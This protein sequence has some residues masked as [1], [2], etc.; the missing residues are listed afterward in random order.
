MEVPLKIKYREVTRLPEAHVAGA[1]SARAVTNHGECGPLCPAHLRP[2]R[3]FVVFLLLEQ[4][5]GESCVR[6]CPSHPVESSNFSSGDCRSDPVIGE[7][8]ISSW[9]S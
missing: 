1:G 3:P 7:G 2:S 6:H 4:L 8:L 9:G 5:L